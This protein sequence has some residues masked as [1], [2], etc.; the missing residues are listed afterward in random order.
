M[1]TDQLFPSEPMFSPVITRFFPING[2]LGDSR[3]ARDHGWAGKTIRFLTSP[4]LRLTRGQR[5]RS[6]RPGGPSRLESRCESRATG[7]VRGALTAAAGCGVMGA[8][9]ADFRAPHRRVPT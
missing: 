8:F 3:E 4:P 1:L 5:R 6:G 7:P 2:P 9:A